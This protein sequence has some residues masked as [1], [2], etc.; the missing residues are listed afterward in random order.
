LLFYSGIDHQNK[1]NMY[2]VI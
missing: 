2:L 1:D